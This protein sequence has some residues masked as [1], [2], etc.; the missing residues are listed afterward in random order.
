MEGGREGGREG[1]KKGPHSM[2][3]SAQVKWRNTKTKS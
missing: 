3:T 1:G 2:E